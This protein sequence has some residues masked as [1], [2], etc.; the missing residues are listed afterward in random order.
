MGTSSSNATP[1]PSN[2]GT[3]S[4]GVV[5]RYGSQIRRGPKWSTG[6]VGSIEVVAPRRNSH[7]PTNIPPPAMVQEPSLELS[8]LPKYEKASKQ[9][10]IAFICTICHVY[11]RDNI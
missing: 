8:K 4:T 6:K 10:V 1:W 3:I 2:V 9:D 11:F 7:V 5:L